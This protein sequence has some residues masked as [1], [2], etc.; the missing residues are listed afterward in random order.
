MWLPAW[1]APKISLSKDRRV[2]LREIKRCGE[3]K[4]REGLAIHSPAASDCGPRRGPHRS[5]DGS[6]AQSWRWRADGWPGCQSAS[7]RAG[8]TVQKEHVEG[9]AGVCSLWFD[10]AWRGLT[11]TSSWWGGH[12][13]KNNNRRQQTREPPLSDGIL[14]LTTPALVFGLNHLDNVQTYLH[15]N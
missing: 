9:A 5:H 8:P 13:A 6:R 1:L 7:T 10:A 12:N 3:K 11:D 2:K 4:Q 14:L 15:G